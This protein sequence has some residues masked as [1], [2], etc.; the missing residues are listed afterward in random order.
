MAGPNTKKPENVHATALVVGETGVLIVG[1]SGTGKSAIARDL[2]RTAGDAGRFAA[3]VA[4]DQVLLET[5]ADRVIASAPETIA[6]LVEIRGSVIAS[7]SHLPRAMVHL[8]IS[9]DPS[10]DNPR[11]PD[12][13]DQY[14][15]G[16][17]VALPLLRFQPGGRNNP[18]DL[19]DA[20]E[21]HQL[22]S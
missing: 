14:D 22:L 8:V 20:F 12:P 2:I 4:D 11:L 7:V 9:L 5:Y 19:L 3:L 15:L 16:I 1:G 18:M 21:K 10:T 6:G 13:E 17:G